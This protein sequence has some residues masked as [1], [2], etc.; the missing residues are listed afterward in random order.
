MDRSL[1]SSVQMM[2]KMKKEAKGVGLAQK[3]LECQGIVLVG[4]FLHMEKSTQTNCSLAEVT[5]EVILGRN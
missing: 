2:G 4:R 5:V 3:K 1:Q